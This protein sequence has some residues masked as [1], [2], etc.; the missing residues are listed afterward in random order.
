M[1]WLSF[2]ARV[3]ET[4]GPHYMGAAPSG[5]RYLRGS[6]SRGVMAAR[7]GDLRVVVNL[8]DAPYQ[9][10]AVTVGAHDFDARAGTVEMR[11]PP[12]MP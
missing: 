12:G 2:L 11:M 4:L 9:D 1:R 8:S 6:G 7:Y 5:F 10:G 3:Q